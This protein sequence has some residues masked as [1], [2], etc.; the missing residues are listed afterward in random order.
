MKLLYIFRK[1]I[2]KF[3][4]L[5]FF[6]VA[7][8]L[9]FFHNFFNKNLKI[10]N[11]FEITKD[12][13]NLDKNSYLKYCNELKNDQE[14]RLKYES[15]TINEIKKFELK[16]EKEEHL[17]MLYV[18]IRALKPRKIVSTGVALGFQEAVILSAINK[19]E[20]GE[21]I[22]IDLL[23]K[24]D[25]LTYDVD[26]KEDETGFYIPEIYKKNWKLIIGD[27]RTELS[28]ILEKMDVDIFIHDS[29]H[30]VSHMVF[31]YSLSRVNLKEGKF[32]FS[33]DILIYNNCFEEFLKLNN[34]VGCSNFPK[35]NYGFF[36]NK[37]SNFEKENSVEKYFK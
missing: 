16:I 14:M 25:Q 4:H 35:L 18:F 27:T 19:N 34:L 7:N 37:F 6:L 30:T 12:Y 36:A 28:K 26:L 1:I 31:E 8:I 17:K 3:L 11:N 23:G 2:F 24:K 21:L 29:N 15:L 22:S 13:L 33:D 10:L 20:I 32:I 5:K 9:R